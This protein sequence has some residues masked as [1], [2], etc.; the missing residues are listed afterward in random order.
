MTDKDKINCD[1]KKWDVCKKDKIEE[2]NKKMCQPWLDQC[3]KSDKKDDKKDDDKKE[4]D[5]KEEGPSKAK[6]ILV[7]VIAG[8]VILLIAGAIAW[9]AW[10]GTRRM[11]GKHW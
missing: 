5:K 8:L 9:K 6:I 2:K 4:D 7:S 10:V 1:D 11:G 3:K